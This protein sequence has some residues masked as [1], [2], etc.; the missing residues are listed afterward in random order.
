[1]NFKEELQKIYYKSNKKTYGE[2][3]KQCLRA[4]E[5]SDDTFFDSDEVTEDDMS[6]LANEG[7]NVEYH[8]D[9]HCYEVSW[10]RNK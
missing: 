2:I 3:K 8:K 6:R 5:W 4:A 1:M 10:K 9:N 7:L